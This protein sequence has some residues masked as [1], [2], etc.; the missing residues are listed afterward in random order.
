MISVVY[1]RTVRMVNVIWCGNV[2]TNDF[3][4]GDVAFGARAWF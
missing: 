4:V 3:D 2:E 1:R